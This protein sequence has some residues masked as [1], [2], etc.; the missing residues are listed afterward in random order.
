[1]LGPARLLSA[2]DRHAVTLARTGCVG[3]PPLG[4]GLVLLETTGRRT[5]RTFARPVL[6]LR[7]GDRLV[8]GTVRRRSDWVANLR[9]RPATVAWGRGGSRRVLA[10]VNRL[11]L[12]SLALLSPDDEIATAPAGDRRDGG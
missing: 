2:F 10:S 4:V 3:P 7:V 8:V 1:M 12:G 5:G 11:P 6:G 9:A